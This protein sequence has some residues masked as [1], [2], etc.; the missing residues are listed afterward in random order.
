MIISD[1]ID[2]LKIL[3]NFNTYTIEDIS[4][5][6]ESQGYK[7]LSKD[8]IKKLKSYKNQGAT[9]SDLLSEELIQ[10]K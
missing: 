6:L 2:A 1:I 7:K 5:L 3:E 4:E 8:E 10:L 9:N